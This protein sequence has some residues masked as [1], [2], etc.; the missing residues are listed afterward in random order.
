MMRVRRQAG[1]PR[2]A[3][4]DLL[5]GMCSQGLRDE[6]RTRSLAAPPE[7]L[8][9]S[10]HPGCGCQQGR[11]MRDLGSATDQHWAVSQ[12]YGDIGAAVNPS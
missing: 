2:V 9:S 11:G 5:I 8:L 7:L 10:R 1:N 12:A 4:R 3:D 6:L